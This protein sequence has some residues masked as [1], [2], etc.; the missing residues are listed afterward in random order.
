MRK[1]NLRIQQDDS[2]NLK[3]LRDGQKMMIH[4]L[5]ASLIINSALRSNPDEVLYFLSIFVAII[6]VMGIL[7]VSKGLA[8][9]TWQKVL[10]ALAMFIPG[11]SI[12]VMIVINIKATRILR[13]AGYEVGFFGVKD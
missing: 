2:G 9:E 13:A 4:T 5:L 3:L 10:A 6:A 12:I 1:N 11:V 8:L 7:K